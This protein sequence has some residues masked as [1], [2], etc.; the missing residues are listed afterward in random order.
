MEEKKLQQL[1]KS[2]EVF[3]QDLFE[4][5]PS[6]NIILQ[7]PRSRTRIMMKQKGKVPVEEQV[8]KHVKKKLVSKAKE[9]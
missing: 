9:S 3:F 2:G 7:C 5:G 6:S 4:K 8:E 1:V